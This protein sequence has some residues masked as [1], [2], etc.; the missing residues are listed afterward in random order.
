MSDMKCMIHLTV[1]KNNNHSIKQE[2]VLK[3]I[4]YMYKYKFIINE[5]RRDREIHYYNA[6]YLHFRVSGLYM[7]YTQCL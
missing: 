7:V 5:V 3:S 6:L 2:I 4:I 1:H